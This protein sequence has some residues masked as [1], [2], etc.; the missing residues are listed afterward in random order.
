MGTMKLSDIEGFPTEVAVS[1]ENLD[2]IISVMEESVSELISTPLVDAHSNL[3]PLERARYDT[4][5][6][7]AVTSLYWA[8]MKANGND[9][10]ANGM[11]E[12]LE[13]VKDAVTRA[14][15]IADRELAPKV[16]VSAAKRFIRQG[17]KTVQVHPTLMRHLLQKKCVQIILVKINFP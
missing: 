15:Q 7:Y 13:R 9:P 16:D 6:I 12:E 8:Y 4:A 1:V 2:S 11:L 3:K 10:K 14:K 5:S 17:N